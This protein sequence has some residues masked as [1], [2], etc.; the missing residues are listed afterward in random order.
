M[1][2]VT[3]EAITPMNVGRTFLGTPAEPSP[4]S[5][6]EPTLANRRAWV[7]NQLHHMWG[8]PPLLEEA[9]KSCNR[10]KDMPKES[11]LHFTW[12][13]IAEDP[14]WAPQPINPVGDNNVDGVVADASD[15]VIPGVKELL[16]SKD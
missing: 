11:H 3:F 5:N 7:M 9:R 15:A 1:L 2:K 6:T 13:V 4:I 16:T 12:S 10:C 8:T 14:Q